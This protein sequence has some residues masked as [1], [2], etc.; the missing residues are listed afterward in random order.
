MM[1]NIKAMA[2]LKPARIVII[3]RTCLAMVNLRLLMTEVVELSMNGNPAVLSSVCLAQTPFAPF[4]SSNNMFQPSMV[5][6][7]SR[8]GLFALRG[9]RRER[10]VETNTGVEA[11]QRTEP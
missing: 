8:Q 2:V 4:R 9:E 11:P 6:L 5:V 10:L 3:D 7:I 1:A